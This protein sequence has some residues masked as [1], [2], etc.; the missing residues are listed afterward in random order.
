MIDGYNLIKS[1]HPSDLKKGG[2]YIYYK[3]YIPLILQD[4]INT[5]GNC[6]LTEIHSQNKKYFLTCTYCSPS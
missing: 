2:V 3:E 4:D 5:L 1:N 6:L